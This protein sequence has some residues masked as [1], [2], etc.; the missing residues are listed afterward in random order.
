M[1]TTTVAP[2]IRKKKVPGS[3]TST[4]VPIKKIVGRENFYGIE[5][6]KEKTTRSLLMSSLNRCNY[7]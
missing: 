2:R 1:R 4:C 7:I 5:I 3:A 6:T